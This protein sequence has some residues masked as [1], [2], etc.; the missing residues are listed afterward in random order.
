MLEKASEVATSNTSRIFSKDLFVSTFSSA[1]GVDSLSSTDLTVLL[2]HLS[3]DRS[4]ISY[5]PSSGVVKFKAPSES[6]S[7]P[8]TQEDISIANL[9]TLISSLEPQ[10]QQLTSRISDFDKKAR[11]AVS[12][13]QLVSARFALRTKKLAED[14]LKQRTATLT[15]LEEVYAKIEQ[16]ADQVEMVKVMESSSKTL[17][18]LNQQTGGVEKVHDVADGLRDEMMNVDEIGQA[19][20]EVSAGQ[21]DEGEVEDELEALEKAER[22][23][24][25]EAERQE[26]EKRE[27]EEA[28]ATRKRLAELDA[29]G[30]EQKLEESAIE[31][32][33]DVAASN[34]S[35]MKATE[36]VE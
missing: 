29:V 24:Q 22:E 25:E 30:D 31:P 18:S 8:V 34:T 23:K 20:N 17:K 14:Q 12:S 28:E 5:S 1:I 19:I 21:I 26:R 11:E 15:Q 4:A 33:G 10:V 36:A 7:M 16:A 27:A 6:E 35:A 32:T 3:R 9:R 13:K 2:R